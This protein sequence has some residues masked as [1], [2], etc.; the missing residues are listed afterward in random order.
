MPLPDIVVKTANNRYAA[1]IEN[2]VQKPVFIKIK[3]N[4]KTVKR[5]MGH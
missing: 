5:V 3:E 1:K 4:I 2:I